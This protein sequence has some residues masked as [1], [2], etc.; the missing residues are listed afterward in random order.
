MTL[1]SLAMAVFGIKFFDEEKYS[2][3]MIKGPLEKFIREAYFGGNVGCFIDKTNS[4]QST[5]M[6]S[7]GISNNNMSNN[8][9]SSSLSF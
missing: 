6:G 7:N 4:V 1:P 2:I 5:G 8:N 9:M 3:K